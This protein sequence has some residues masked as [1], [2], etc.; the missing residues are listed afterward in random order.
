MAQATVTIIG[1][2]GG[3]PELRFV[4]NGAAVANFNVA[5]T[6]RIKDGEQW[7]DGITTWYRC[8]IWRD[9]AEHVAESLKKGDQVI[10]T[11]RIK[12]RPYDKDGQQRL[13]LEIDVDEVGP[14]LRFATASVQ[15]A[16][17]SGGGNGNGAPA[18]D[19]WGATKTADTPPW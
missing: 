17:R 16:G 4:P 15:K 11:G 13:S 19:P 7:K 6:E 14:T 12:N 3:D 18:S 8:N 10:V 2:L 1:A 9:Y 5:V